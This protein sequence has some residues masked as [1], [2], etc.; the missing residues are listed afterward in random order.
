[1]NANSKAK[2]REALDLLQTAAKD[3]RA[4]LQEMAKN[5]YVDLKSALGDVRDT[6]NEGGGRLTEFKERGQEK[7]REIGTH[8]DEYVRNDPWRTIGIVAACSLV[9]GFLLNRGRS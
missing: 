2:I 9:A 4:Q 8:V 6:L 1:M 7:V 5:R 3:E